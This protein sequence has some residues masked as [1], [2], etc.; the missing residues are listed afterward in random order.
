MLRKGENPMNLIGSAIISEQVSVVADMIPSIPDIDSLM[1]RVPMTPFQLSLERQNGTLALLFLQH[2]ANPLVRSPA[3]QCSPLTTLAMRPLGTH[4]REIIESL[5]ARGMSFRSDRSPF[6]LLYRRAVYEGWTEVSSYLLSKVSCEEKEDLEM[7]LVPSLIYQNSSASLGPLHFLLEPQH[8]HEGGRAS[9]VAHRGHQHTLF[10][11]LLVIPEDICDNTLNHH[12]LRYLLSKFS[13]SAQI[14]AQDRY[15]TTAVANAVRTGKVRGVIA[16]LENN[17]DPFAGRLSAVILAVDRCIPGKL[18]SVSGS[19]L[20]V[21]GRYRTARRYD[22]NSIRV[23]W[24]LLKWYIKGK[25]SEPSSANDWR[26]MTISDLQDI[27]QG[28]ASDTF[29][30]EV[31]ARAIQK[32][33]IGASVTTSGKRDEPPRLVATMRKEKLFLEK[34]GVEGS[35][36]PATFDEMKTGTCKRSAS[37]GMSGLMGLGRPAIMGIW[38]VVVVAVMRKMAMSNQ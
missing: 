2:G 35:F 1:T 17:A 36:R 24:E 9:F 18:A 3:V 8:N 4:D 23:L 5:M 33:A 6:Q 16:L 27:L 31:M 11:R 7:D 15:G 30:N 32:A 28:F 20:G 10:H 22:E 37:T 13:S 21:L 38:D 34:V 29:R 14:N 25:G 19:F 26:T 12:I